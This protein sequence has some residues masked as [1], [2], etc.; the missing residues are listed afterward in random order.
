MKLFKKLLSVAFTFLL[1]FNGGI[2]LF[3]TSNKA[4]AAFDVFGVQ[5]FKDNTICIVMAGSTSS[6]SLNLAN[7]I[8]NQDSVQAK[9]SSS[10][11]FCPAPPFFTGGALLTTTPKTIQADPNVQSLGRGIL[12]SEIPG[13]SSGVS[14]GDPGGFN[15]LIATLGGVNGLTTSIFE[16]SLPSG[17]D[18][19]DDDNDIEGASSDLSLINDFSFPTCTSTN[20]L[21][22]QCNAASNLLTAINGLVPASGS[23]PAKIRFAISAFDSVTDGNMID[24]ILIRLDSQDIFCPSTLSG[25][26]TATVIAKNAVDNPTISQTLGTANIG[27]PAQAVK[28]GYAPESATSLKGEVS[29]NQI[30]TTATLTGG[31]NTT[32]NTIQIDEL[33]N[34][35]IPVGGQTSPI[36]VNPSL[37]STSSINTSEITT[38]NL[39]LVPSS[40]TLFF[41]VPSTSDI[42]FSDSSLTISSAPY[43]VMTNTDDTN[44]PFGTLVIPIKKNTSATDPSTVKTTITIK[45]LICTAGTQDST[46]SLALFEPI[47]GAI[48][49]TPAALSVNDST[50]LTNPQN[51]SAFSAASTRAL[52]QNAVVGGA[53]NESTGAAQVTTDADLLALTSRN[54]TL[55]APQITS[56]TKVVSSLTT[57]DVSKITVE[58]FQGTSLTINA[59]AGASIGGAK[60]KIELFANGQTTAFDSVTVTSKS[61]GSFTAK[62]KADFSAGDITLKFKQTVSTSDSQVSS[63]TFSKQSITSPTLAC[64]K[65]VCGCENVNCTPT[66]SNV[67][68]FIQS[69]GGLS[70]IV[71]SGGDLL[72]EV[73]NAAKKALGLS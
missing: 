37:S 69:N 27:T 54:T 44:A 22:V 6:E 56:F 16:I 21:T 59:G 18:V 48:V 73:I 2:F 49:N 41:L 24:T 19:V 68:N 65:T 45:N 29:T 13:N 64:E 31:A 14:S 55:G 66:V 47:S 42:T 67:L 10:G 53:V 17:C 26:L 57:V 63:K 8:T 35:G 20:G 61:D 12:I 4:H 72:Q 70:E 33:H 11:S 71:S 3:Y 50:N 15:S 9:V 52:A 30:D 28:V 62:L 5:L 58:A 1:L 36:L 23:S 39:W 51:F 40:T 25:P 43:I 34:E 46:V 32:A 7:F 60:I 38:I